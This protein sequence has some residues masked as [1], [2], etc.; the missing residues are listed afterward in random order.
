MLGLRQ[1]SST[2]AEY[3]SFESRLP[4]SSSSLT[5][6]SNPTSCPLAPLPP[7]PDHG[8][9]ISMTYPPVLARSARSNPEIEPAPR[10]SSTASPYRNT[11]W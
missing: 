8:T 7:A 3:V 9:A 4:P 1:A 6:T 10:N 11:I 5:W 2:R